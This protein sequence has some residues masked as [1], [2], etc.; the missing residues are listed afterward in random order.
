MTSPTQWTWV[1]VNSECWWWTGKP[2]MLQSMVLQRVRH[3][4][5]TELNWTES[6]WIFFFK[7]SSAFQW[8]LIWVED[9]EALSHMSSW[10]LPLQ[11]SL[12]VQKGFFA[13]VF[14]G[15]KLLWC[16]YKFFSTGWFM[17]ST[18]GPLVFALVMKRQS[19]R[20]WKYYYY[21]FPLRCLTLANQSF[22][23]F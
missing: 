18:L 16:H 3:N 4:S 17:I 13:P 15:G 11:M 12:P 21:F 19:F 10:S 7:S 20:V 1:W 9:Q 2:G 8:I 14:V 6:L 22:F 5:V 23:D